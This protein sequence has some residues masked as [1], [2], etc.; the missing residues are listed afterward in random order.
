M[1]KK[2]VKHSGPLKNM[3]KY[4]YKL[5]MDYIFFNDM[6]IIRKNTFIHRILFCTAITIHYRPREKR[7]EG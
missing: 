1:F 6:V 7:K 4:I 2:S 5:W 3:L